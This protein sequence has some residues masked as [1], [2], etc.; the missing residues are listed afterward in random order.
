MLTVVTITRFAMPAI[1]TFDWFR[2]E[3]SPMVD[4]EIRKFLD[5]QRDYILDIRNEN[6]RRRLTDKLIMQVKDM[7]KKTKS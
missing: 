4:D 3:V 6:E 5:R 1:E 2:K 7:M